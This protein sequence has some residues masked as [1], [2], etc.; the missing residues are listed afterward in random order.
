MNASLLTYR[1]EASNPHAF[2]ELSFVQLIDRVTTDDGVE[3]P[4]GAEGTVVAIW[5]EGAAYEVDFAAGLATVEAN[6]L[7]A[8]SSRK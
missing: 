7:E 2:E 3:V 4:E 1:F 5:A 8:A 6:Q